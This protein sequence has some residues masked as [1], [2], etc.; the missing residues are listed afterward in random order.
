MVGYHGIAVLFKERN[1]DGHGENTTVDIVQSDPAM[2]PDKYGPGERIQAQ[3]AIETRQVRLRSEKKIEKPEVERLESWFREL[4][5]L[6][7]WAEPTF[8][9]TTAA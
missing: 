2:R 7:N 1:W 3:P 8:H 5:I 9:A 6:S 4:R